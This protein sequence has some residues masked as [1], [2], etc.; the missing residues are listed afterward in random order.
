MKKRMISLFMV[1][2]VLCAMMVMPASVSA[3]FVDVGEFPYLETFDSYTEGSFTWSPSWYTSNF[4][5]DE[6]DV[7]YS[8][9][10]A[11]GGSGLGLELFIEA[12]DYTVVHEFIDKSPGEA[13]TVR[14]PS[15]LDETK[16]YRFSFM[17]K[18]S[19]AF[20]NN[21]I[22]FM[23]YQTQA[24]YARLG[25]YHMPVTTD[26]QCLSFVVGS[27]D[28]PY[29]EFNYT[30]EPLFTT[31]WLAA[32]FYVE[33]AG[34]S[35]GASLYIDNFK[36]EEFSPE[37]SSESRELINDG[38]FEKIPLYDGQPVHTESYAPVGGQPPYPGLDNWTFYDNVVGGNGTATF[39][40]DAASTGKY[41][42][43][44]FG[45]SIPENSDSSTQLNYKIRDFDNTKVYRIQFS[46]NNDSASHL[47]RFAPMY[48][49]YTSMFEAMF[50][51]T[52]A[53]DYSFLIA[54]L[55]SNIPGVLYEYD[56]AKVVDGADADADAGLTIQFT[57]MRGATLLLDD[58]SMESVD[59]EGLGKVVPKCA[60]DEFTAASLKADVSLVNETGV[61]IDDMILV[62]AVI[63]ADGA[64]AG[65]DVIGNIDLDTTTVVNPAGTLSFDGDFQGCTLKL[66]VLDGF[67]NLTP[68]GPARPYLLNQY[69][70]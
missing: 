1:L 49:N 41:G 5:A 2:S 38:G 67:G 17:A 36:V 10:A 31:E 47:V 7:K 65:V 39:T 13:G 56:P 8:E 4:T 51:E 44:L 50:L 3:D 22:F 37:N 46:A 64:L 23:P 48:E 62:G 54:P 15:T 70:D 6:G 52:G 40:A 63:G 30:D 19:A 43:E 14:R 55:G 29:T 45:H 20:T 16:N 53:Y 35:T 32:R 28:V 21:Q 24:D 60:I 34:N 66:F 57:A 27:K 25:L 18:K 33:A 12:G 69:I 61:V 11:Y 42:V 26:W 58:F 9:T 59:T 68:L